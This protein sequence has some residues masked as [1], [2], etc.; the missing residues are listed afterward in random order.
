MAQLF[1]RMDPIPETTGSPGRT[2]AEAA[3][4][5]VSPDP[6]TA[7]LLAAHSSGEKLTPSQYGKIGAFASRIKNLFAAKTGGSPG[8]AQPSAPFG[9]P[10]PLGSVAPGEAPG[11]G[12]APVEVDSGIVK[13]TT[14]ALL[15]RCEAIGC[16]VITNAARDAGAADNLVARFDAKARLQKD[17]K[18]LMIELSPDVARELGID[19]HKCASVVFAGTLGLYITDLWLLVNELKKMKAQKPEPNREAA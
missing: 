17:D 8:Q 3:A 13:R 4:G 7:R 12:L 5:A 19:M 15:N 18:E 11:G 1:E 9:Q 10:A 16:R 14:A 2:V 6:E